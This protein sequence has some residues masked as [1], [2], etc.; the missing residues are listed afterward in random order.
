V[1]TALITVVG[2][3]GS[4]GLLAP[5]LI[6]SALLLAVLP[7]FSLSVT[8][9]AAAAAAARR[10]QH[11]APMALL[12]LVVTIRSWTTSASPRSCRSTISIS[13][14][15][16]RARRGRCS[17]F[18]LGSGRGRDRRRGGPR[19]PLGALALSCSGSSL[20]ALPFRRACS[21]LV[22]APAFV[23]LGIFGALLTSSFTV[24]VV[25]RDSVPAARNA[26]MA[27][28]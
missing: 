18:F 1:I 8:P 11:A 3:T 19:R 25:P 15:P 9:R 14:A 5:T 24:S 28:A 10:H 2:L 26:G 17:S 7:A 12:I 4:L 23:M 21:C 27:R 16:T 22:R 20:A 6:A 13:S